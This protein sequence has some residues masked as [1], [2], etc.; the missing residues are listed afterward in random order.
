LDR[1]FD[2]LGWL[3]AGEKYIFDVRS[4]PLETICMSGAY[5]SVVC[6]LVGSE[7]PFTEKIE[8]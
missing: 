3:E 7:P 2:E 4:S 8:R 5:V 1:S 6:G